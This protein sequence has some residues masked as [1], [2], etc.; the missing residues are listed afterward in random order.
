MKNYRFSYA[1]GDITHGGMGCGGIFN[2]RFVLRLV[3]LLEQK[4]SQQVQQQ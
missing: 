1:G 4:M 3:R 2:I